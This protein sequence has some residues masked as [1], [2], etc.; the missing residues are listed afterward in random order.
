MKKIAAFLILGSVAAA[1]WAQSNFHWLKDEPITKFSKEDQ[2][3]SLATLQKA[4][5]SGED[6]VPVKWENPA[7]SNSGS[8]TPSPDPKGQAGCRQA[9]IENR[10]QTLHSSSEAVFCKVD[11]KWKLRQKLK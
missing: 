4:L 6:G 2:Q 11:G 5:D 10:H 8:V 9:R 1:S 3:T 7:A